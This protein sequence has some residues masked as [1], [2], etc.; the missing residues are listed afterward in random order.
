[1]SGNERQVRV[2]VLG[3]A[4]IAVRR[5]L[6]A[7]V[8]A[9]GVSVSGIASRD[10]RRA[11]EVVG[12]FGGEPFDD[13]G[14]LL[15]SPSVEAVYIPLPSGLHAEWV[16]RA[17]LAGKHVLAEKPLTTSGAETAR[18]MRLADSQGL[19]LGENF[20]FLRHS[21]HATVL[22]MLRDNVIGTVHLF[23]SCFSVPARPPGD[24]RHDPEL[25]GGALLDV[26]GYPIRAAQY[27]FGE[28][29]EV[30]GAVLREDTT[31]G[32]DTGGAAL[33]ETEGGVSVHASFGLD[34]AYRSHYE[35]T[36]S[37]GRISLENAFTPSGDH[38]PVLNISSREGTE[39]RTLSPQDQYVRSVEHFRNV[40]LGNASYE[41]SRIIRQ[42][43]L[44]DAVRAAASRKS[45][46][47][48]GTSAG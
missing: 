9:E 5:V 8:A 41:R 12:R 27:F 4:D 6:P 43:E 40:V 18:L 47:G 30:R 38:A 2:G 11:R 42:G 24:V 15:E 29:L 22:G 32:V 16:E 7:F 13:Y 48:V 28:G 34:H 14:E 17:L 1:M 3:C 19:A 20:M 35:F 26:G 10:P 36:G 25:G 44:V 46:S 31:Y 23:S 37:T 45:P 39:T 33:L 21:Q